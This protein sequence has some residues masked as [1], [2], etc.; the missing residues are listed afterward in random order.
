MV[1]GFRG[2]VFLEAFW[3]Y[4]CVPDMNKTSIQRY[5]PNKNKKSDVELQNQ[6]LNNLNV[7]IVWTFLKT[8]NTGVQ[9]ILA[10][11]ILCRERVSKFEREIYI[12]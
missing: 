6:M 9:I 10:I 1:L 5:L 11:S 2:L 3:I 7:N 4:V 12:D 8:G